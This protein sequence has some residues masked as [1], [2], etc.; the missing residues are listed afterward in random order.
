[1][2]KLGQT[3]STLNRYRRHWSTLLQTTGAKGSAGA[4]S[5]AAD[6][7]TELTGFGSNPGALRR[8]ACSRGPSPRSSAARWTNAA[9]SD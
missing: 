5:A 1:M 6:H 3:I 8:M 4:P 7:L 2:R 9:G